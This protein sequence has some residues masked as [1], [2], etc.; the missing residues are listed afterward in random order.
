MKG[1][2]VIPLAINDRVGQ[3]QVA[4]RGGSS[5][6]VTATD[7]VADGLEFQLLEAQIRGELSRGALKNMVL[8]HLDPLRGAAIACSNPLVAAAL[9]A[10]S[11]WELLPWVAL[12]DKKQRAAIVTCVRYGEVEVEDLIEFDL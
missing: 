11:A 3:K 5:I 6:E 9:M 1:A 7:R 12:Y 2:L 4:S 8:P 10:H